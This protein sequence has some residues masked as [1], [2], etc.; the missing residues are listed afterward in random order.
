MTTIWIIIYNIIIVPLEYLFYQIAR[1][2]NTKISDGIKG[3]INQ[4]EHIVDFLRNI[5]NSKPLCLFHCVSVGE[6]EQ[7]LPVIIRLKEINPDIIIV[8][9]FFSPSGY[10]YIKKNLYVDLILYLPFDSYYRAKSFL[11]LLNPHIW[12]VSKHDVWPNHLFAAKKLNIPVVLID[13]TLPPNSR[14]LNPLV[15]QFNRSVYSGFHFMFPISEGDRDRFMKIY[16]HNDR[17][18]ITGDTRFDQVNNRAQKVLREDKIDLFEDENAKTIIAG[19]IWPSDEKH[20]IPAVSRLLK[21]YNNLN[22]VLVPHET[23]ENHLISIGNLLK[24][25]NIAFSRFSEIESG[26]RIQDRVIIIDVIGI[27]AKLYAQTDI[28]FVGGSFGPGVHN[29]MEPGILGKPV[30]FGPRHLNS[31]EAVE[32]TKCGGGFI[33]NNPDEL[34]ERICSFMDDESFLKTSGEN[35]KGLIQKNL[36]ATEKIIDNL[37]KKYDF[38][39]KEDTDRNN[40]I[41]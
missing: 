30:L 14:R 28:A 3:R 10:N 37:R 18:I 5:D 21:K 32:L 7:A 8:V 9:T 20:V 22:V 13:A 26:K 6:W 27:L 11:K 34:Y 19:S 31:H 33:V 1:N 40:N 38:I 4:K 36:G 35:A 2:F 12:F 29:V 16:P 17:M 39:S 41:M 15:R 25:E 23:D 24:A